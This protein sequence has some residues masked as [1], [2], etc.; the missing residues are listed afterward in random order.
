MLTN[1]EAGAS[2]LLIFQRTGDGVTVKAII[3]VRADGSVVVATY[4]GAI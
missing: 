4:M 3:Y 1:A 2:R